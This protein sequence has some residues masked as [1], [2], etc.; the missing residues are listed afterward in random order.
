MS[1]LQYEVLVGLEIHV[2]LCTKSKM[3]CGCAVEF[4]A[5]ANSR[6]CPVCV[7]MPG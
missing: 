3:F 6:V 7:G 1:E 5:T 4:G 2:Q